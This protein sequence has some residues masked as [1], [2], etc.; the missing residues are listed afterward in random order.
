MWERIR[1]SS[2]YRLFDQHREVILY[3]FFGGLTF[4]I[5]MA[6]YTICLKLL[7]MNELIANVISWILAVLFAFFTNRKWVFNG[8]RDSAKGFWAQ[9]LSFFGGRIFTLI[10]EELIL[11]V[12][13]TWLKLD[14]VAVK[15]VAQVVVIVLNYFISKFFVFRGKG[16]S[17]K[18]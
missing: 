14:G 16:E 12:F 5:S 2:L 17:A 7:G 8:E 15:A 11:L 10:V 4:V 3:L 18:K 6:S 9:M 13:V 1:S